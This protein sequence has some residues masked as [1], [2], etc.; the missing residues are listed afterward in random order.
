MVATAGQVPPP[1]PA[2]RGGHL[3]A[4]R[5]RQLVDV[6]VFPAPN[7][8]T[9]C[10]CKIPARIKDDSSE[11][12]R[13][14][15]PSSGRASEASDPQGPGPG[16]TGAGIRPLLGHLGCPYLPAERIRRREPLGCGIRAL[17]SSPGSLLPLFHLQ[18]GY[19]LRDSVSQVCQLPLPPS[20][21]TRGTQ[22]TDSF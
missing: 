9:T 3:V 5:C 10:F 1:V 22:H 12:K 13:T 20:C 8:Q 4:R 6:S 18:H 17:S 16:R 19:P 21:E 14:A 15:C 2:W 11:R 7:P